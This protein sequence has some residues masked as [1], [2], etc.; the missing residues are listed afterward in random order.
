MPDKSKIKGNNDSL[1]NSTWSGDLQYSLNFLA[2]KIYAQ[3]RNDGT[4]AVV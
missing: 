4:Y 2:N 3:K 1:F